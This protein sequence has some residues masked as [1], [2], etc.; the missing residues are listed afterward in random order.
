VPS[1]S[2]AMSHGSEVVVISPTVV[3]GAL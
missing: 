1:I 2:S 3:S